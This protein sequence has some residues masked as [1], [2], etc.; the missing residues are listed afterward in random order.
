MVGQYF[1]LK[2]FSMFHCL[3]YSAGE[4]ANTTAAGEHAGILKLSTKSTVK[5][6]LSPCTKR[7]VV[8]RELDHL[9]IVSAWVWLR[10]D[11]LAAWAPNE[12]LPSRTI[13]GMVI[14]ESPKVQCLA[15]AFTIYLWLTQAQ[16][17]VVFGNLQKVRCYFGTERDVSQ[18]N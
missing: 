5:P 2:L 11:L 12:Y 17:C 16:V 6:S 15:P 4:A 10:R 3:P 13:P 1:L 8:S 18:L 7:N 14:P 9:K